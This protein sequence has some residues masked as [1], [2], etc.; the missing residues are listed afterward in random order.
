[1]INHPRRRPRVES[2]IFRDLWWLVRMEAL[3]M[4]TCHGVPYHDQQGWRK[5]L[6]LKHR[7]RS[8]QVGE[9]ILVKIPS[10]RFL[11]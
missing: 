3:Y 11:P 8:R 10:R 2:V 7:D 6:F 9:A 5:H 1:M 4:I